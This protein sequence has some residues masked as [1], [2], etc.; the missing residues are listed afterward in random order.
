MFIAL[1]TL[2]W[3]CNALPVYLVGSALEITAVTVTRNWLRYISHLYSN[4]TII[5]IHEFHG[6]TC[7]NS[8]TKLQGQ[9]VRGV[10]VFVLRSMINSAIVGLHAVQHSSGNTRLLNAALSRLLDTLSLS[11]S[12]SWPI[13]GLDVAWHRPPSRV[14]SHSS[15]L[16]GRRPLSERH[17]GASAS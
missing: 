9:K 2:F 11:I 4:F 7:L 16:I 6:D 12:V 8:Q 3:L 15:N 1:E 13:A 14:L 5:I 10:D 17:V